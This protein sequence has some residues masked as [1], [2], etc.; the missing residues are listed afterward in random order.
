MG[1]SVTTGAAGGLSFFSAFSLQ[2]SALYGLTSTP[3]TIEDEMV[4]LPKLKHVGLALVQFVYSLHPG[5]F[6]KKTEWVYGPNFIAISIRFKRT[7]KIELSL[8]NCPV[9]I[10]D[11][12]VLPV[13]FGRWDYGRCEVNSPRQLACAARYVEAAFQIWH[14]SVFGY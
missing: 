7:E 8:K 3:M 6:T 10:E 5:I 9:Q 14:K 12:K 11:P 4:L 13:S 1:C 2:D